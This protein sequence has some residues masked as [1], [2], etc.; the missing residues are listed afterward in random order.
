[1]TEQNISIRT[2]DGLRLEGTLDAPVR[3]PPWPGVVLAHPHPWYGGSK[4]VPLVRAIAAALARRGLAVL[5]FNFRGVGRSE[6]RF[7][8][9]ERAV[10]DVAA[11]VEALLALPQVDAG[12]CALAGY[13]FGAWVGLR[14]FAQDTRLRAFAAVGMPLW[15]QSPAWFR[16]DG[17]PRLFVTGSL[18][19]ISPPDALR[20]LLVGA[21]EAQ[22]EVLEG[23]DHLY[24]PPHQRAVAERIARFL[25]DLLSQEEG[26]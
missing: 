14:H 22:L 18:D 11:A 21:E 8:P 3:P 12:R 5:R 4:D 24:A 26:P 2:P 16:G 7:H 20:P 10:Q 6:G 19:D 13:S 9:D 1:M 25:S 17:R 23:A 15:D